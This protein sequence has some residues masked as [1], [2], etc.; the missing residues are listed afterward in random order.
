MNTTNQVFASL[1]IKNYYS[2]KVWSNNLNNLL[3][4]Y[5]AKN[6]KFEIIDIDAEGSDYKILKS[7]DFKKYSFKLILIETHTFSKKTKAEKRKIYAF[8]KSK[9][10]NCLKE[11]HETSIFENTKWKN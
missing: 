8:L 4:R 6:N 1:F 7:I 3:K 2:R 9:K 5:S 11:L 10:Y